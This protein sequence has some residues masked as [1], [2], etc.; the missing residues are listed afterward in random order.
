M[1]RDIYSAMGG[2]LFVLQETVRAETEFFYHLE[3]AFALHARRGEH[4]VRDGCVCAAS[5]R[6]L[7]VVAQHLSAAGKTQERMR[8]DE[9]VNRHDAAEFVVRERF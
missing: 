7:A 1:L 3:I 2:G 4:V 6:L 8:V 9:S 5:E